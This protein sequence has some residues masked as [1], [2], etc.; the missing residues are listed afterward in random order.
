MYTNINAPTY[1]PIRRLFIELRK[2][3]WVCA[4]RE[5]TENYTKDS[6][7]HGKVKVSVSPAGVVPNLDP[8]AYYNP[9]S[10]E[11]AFAYCQR[12][13]FSFCSRRSSFCSH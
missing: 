5:E 1:R 2:T 8:P 12:P 7:S 10:C 4:Q 11:R 6:V 13:I 9:P 3:S